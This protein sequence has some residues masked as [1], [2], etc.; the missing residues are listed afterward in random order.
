MQN[1]AET[2]TTERSLFKQVT[3]ATALIAWATD[4]DGRCFYIS[5]AW[6]RFTGAETGDLDWLDQVRTDEHDVV[7][8]AFA[9]ANERKIAFGMPYW[10]QRHDGGYTRVWDVGLPKFDESYEFRGY[11]GTVC[12]LDEAESAPLL[13]QEAPKL[14]PREREVLG[15]VADGNTSDTIAAILNIA[16]RTVEAHVTNAATKLGAHNRVHAVTMA[17]RKN[18]L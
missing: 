9:Q 12:P 4:E 16:P 3:E 18:E 2:W 6:Y 5:P 11:F 15:L 17:I 7:G 8:Q 14:T 1:K 10:L 13:R